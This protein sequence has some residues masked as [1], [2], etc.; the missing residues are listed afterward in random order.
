MWSG[1][2]IKG[3]RYEMAQ[4]EEEKN[5]KIYIFGPHENPSQMF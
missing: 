3:D 5:F 1:P 2:Q 4:E